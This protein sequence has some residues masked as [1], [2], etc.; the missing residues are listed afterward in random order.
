[1]NHVDHHSLTG[2]SSSSAIDLTGTP[3]GLG[4]SVPTSPA[5]AP[6]DG[7]GS[8]ARR[9][10]SWGRMEA[11]EDPLRFGSPDEPPNTSTPQRTATQPGWSMHEDPFFSP[12]EEDGPSF[13]HNYGYRSANGGTYTT[14]QPGPSSASLISSSYRTSDPDLQRE[15][16]EAHLTSNMSRLGTHDEWEQ[17]MNADP[18]RSAATA[19][20]RRTLRYSGTPSPL[21][22]T[23]NRLMTISRNLRRVS[24]RVVNMAGAGMD[25]HVRLADVEDEKDVGD[26][27][28]NEEEKDYDVL[29]LEDLSKVMP[30]RGRTLGFMGPTNKLR[31]ALFR[32]L[33]H[34]WT[35]PIILLLILFNSVVLTVQA[36]RNIAPPNDGPPVQYSGFFHGWEDY[37]LLSLF[38]IFTL[39]MFARI[40]VCGL[41]LDPDVPV[42]SLFNF[43][44][45]PPTESK[46]PASTSVPGVSRQTSMVHSTSQAA[47]V[48]RGLTLTARLRRLRNNI[49]RP[50]T[51]AHHSLPVT[52]SSTDESSTKKVSRARSDTVQ[53]KTPMMEKA[54]K[55]HSHLRNP[56]QPTFFS[57]ALRSENQDVLSLPFRLS[58]Q[59]AH[60]AMQRNLPY[61]RHSWTRIDFIAVIS[62]W[63]CIALAVTGVE[64]GKY[65]IG[66]FRALSVLRITRLLAITSGTTTIMRSLKTARPLLASVAYFVL[67]AMIMFSIIGIQSFK[68][69]FRRNCYLLPVNGEDEIALGQSC[70]AYIDNA[71]QVVTGF[72]NRFNETT[73]STKGFVCPLGQICREGSSNPFENV[74]SFDT[75]YY[76]ALQVFIVSSANG[77]S[78]LMY[79]MMDAEFFISCF[80]FIVCVIVLNFWLINLFV[81]VITNTFSAIRKDTHKSAFG[82]APIAPTIQDGEEGWKAL[83]GRRVVKRSKVK[84]FYESIRWCWVALA[85][86]SLVLQGTG[87]V[88]A[89]DTQLEIIDK[90][91]MILTVVFDIEI[92]IRLVAYLPDWRAFAARGQNWLDFILAVG[93][94]VIQIPAVHNSSVYPWLT[95][96]QLT[97][98]YRVILEIPRM[99]PLLLAVFGNMYGLANMSLF[100]FLINYITALVGVQLL[101]GDVG[102]DSTRFIDWGEI[103]NAFLG[104]YQIF[105]SENWTNVLYD[106]AT[107]E[108]ALRQTAIVILFIVGWFFFAN[109]I[110]LQMFIAVINENFD[111]AEEHKRSRQASH[112][113]AAQRPE[114]ARAAWVRRLNPYR[115]FEAK[116]KALAVDQLPSN[117][118]LPMQ[119]SLVQDY[120]FRKEVLRNIQDPSRRGNGAQ[121]VS[122]KSIS[123][124]QTLFT[125]KKMSLDVPL[126]TIRGG[127]RESTIVQEGID[128]E[129]ERHLEVLAALNN[130]TANVEDVN[131]ILYERRAQKADF[132]RDHPTYD[133]TFWTFS[134]KNPL[135]RICQ[136]LVAPAN[137]ERIFGAPPSP[138][139]HPVFQLVLL[140]TVISGIV[141]EWIATPLYRRNYY[142]AHGHIR[143]SWFDIAEAVFGSMLFLEFLIKI[144]ADG[145]L[146]TP[147]AYVRG[148]WNILDFMIMIGVV[149]NL[150]TGLIFIG[151]LSRLTRSLK[152]LRALRLITLIDNMRSTF[153][154]LIIFGAARI[155]DAAL[156]AI[157]YMIPYAIW[158]RNI[159]SGLMNECN[160]SSVSGL[161]TCVN[162]YSNNVVGN[163]FSYLVPRVWNNPSP[164]TTFSFDSFRASL[165]ILFEIVSL[166]GWIDVMS[167]A[168]S[169]TGRDQQPQ[170]NVSQANAIFFVIYNLLG[171]VVILTLFISIIIGNF[172]SRTGSALLTQPQREWIDL[173]KLIMRQRPSKRPKTRPVWPFRAWCYDRAVH[174]HGWW[175]RTMTALFILH[176]VALMTQTFA[177]Q[178]FLD[179]LRDDF[180]L[181]LIVIYIV[182]I[183]VRLYGL[184]WG[185]YSANGWNLFDIVVAGGSLITNIV[186]RVDESGF[187]VQQLQK[188]FI[189]CIAFK[190]VQR[191]NSLNKLFK[192]AVASLPSILSLLSLWLVMFLFFSILFVEVFSMTKWYSAES[193]NQNY[194]SMPKALVMLAFMTTGEGWNQYMHDFAIE[195]PRCTNSVD[196]LF[197]S[198]CGSVGWSF[199]LFIAWNLLSMYIFANL[200]IGVVV[201]SFYY[202]FQMT[203]GAKEITREEMRAFKKVWAEFANSKTGYLE[204]TKFVPFFGRLSGIFE[205]RIY[206]M[207]FSIPQIMARSAGDGSPAS[208][209]SA[210]HP[211]GL[212]IYALQA[213]VNSVDRT[214]MKRRKNLYNRLYH[215]ARISYEPGKGISFTNMLLLLAHH[216]I[217]IDNEALVLQD[218]VVRTETNK[219][220]TDLVDFDKVQSLLLM[221]SQRRRYLAM[222]EKARVQRQMEDGVPDIVVSP[223]EPVTPPTSTRDITSPLTGYLDTPRGQGSVLSPDATFVV[224][225]PSRS[226]LQRSKRI[227]EFSMLSPQESGMRTSFDVSQSRE[228]RDE[229][230]GDVLSSLENSVWGEMLLEAAEEEH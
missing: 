96:F 132:I 35:E 186:V 105:S 118:V 135:R 182:D 120:T 127:K 43:A 3:A 212:D 123:V 91:E 199:T 200:F 18:E 113:W 70:G 25:E 22:K 223:G 147:N 222:R 21:R 39:E 84:D 77:W 63:I 117:L 190:L 126:A 8:F 206:P 88:D 7:R 209:A 211:S 205:V 165:L 38:I 115:W 158:G 169:I 85:L 93:S 73:N 179:E 64:H 128:E 54:E 111:V 196:P 173:Q 72:I 103:F 16:D 45:V 76:S 180:F 66:I 178:D 221:I 202:V 172:T 189:T 30:I 138:I 143:G 55:I 215:E 198:D 161:N 52:S 71:T 69:S 13:T 149:V 5:L 110:V 229:D 28:V 102:Q 193:H 14:S 29:E 48:S 188:L 203:G 154:S 51:L 109:Y 17:N 95:I 226:G 20:S 218:L 106:A 87:S 83:D 15:D 160:D 50:F 142:Q 148:I 137:G 116:P 32:F 9:R 150:T 68:G 225:T 217:I 36:A 220:V 177:P 37:A 42:S 168:V 187:V 47:G 58:V 227:S 99:K 214:V 49:A 4:S 201:E 19:R 112:F 79:S 94:T 56:S 41:L 157:L 121:H 67:F 2:G 90:G 195:Y 130:E 23:G 104:I 78:P 114:K 162:E 219:L 100:L 133:R 166:E 62:F 60:T 24:L 204:R 61:L 82:A 181:G 1:M 131:D 86:A 125:G 53:S 119:K 184:G 107:S 156:L 146:F 185:S 139:A 210:R 175:H 97:R 89:S 6:I 230:T 159:F 164:S 44:F 228:F 163:S 34:R 46:M 141:V 213:N 192:T 155:F 144:I 183:L 167:V 40:A 145:F 33:V 134:Q 98:F 170:Q 59:T 31:L 12:T 152:A 101:R 207:D 57:R 129:T 74:E 153:E 176:V 27:D 208:F 171:G 108:V 136:K 224:D 140:V 124:L 174:K 75:I 92:I 197:E 151:G 26:E 122:K 216:K 81:A 11:T 194:S 10:L 65:H 191:T 80:F